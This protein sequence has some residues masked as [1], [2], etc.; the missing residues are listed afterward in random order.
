MAIVS[1]LAKIFA[2]D[3]ERLKQEIEAFK[4]E[5]N[6]WKSPPGLPNSAGNL[7]LHLVGNL[8]TFIGRDIGKFNYVR[9]REAEFSL[10][11]VPRQK[12]LEQI[13]DVKRIVSASLSGIDDDRLQ[14]VRIEHRL[15]NE[16]TNTYL[17]VHFATHLA[18]HLGQIN[19]LR[20]MLEPS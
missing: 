15:G 1:E 4:L 10:N 17:L 11:G 14:E 3:L 9:N 19:Y 8:N 13:E 2:A 12:L 18:Y 5:E 20:R 16:M 7:C 6:L